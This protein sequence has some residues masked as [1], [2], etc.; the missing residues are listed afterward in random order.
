MISPEEIKQ[1]ALRWWT[2]I[3]LCHIRNEN[4]FPRTIERIG[5]VRPGDVSGQFEKTQR[6]IHTLLRHSKNETGIGYLVEKSDY[7]F[8]RTGSHE[9]PERI[10]I[11]SLND[12]LHITGKKKEW[13]NYENTLIQITAEIPELTVWAE[14]NTAWLVKNNIHWPGILLVCSYF[15]SNPRP[16]MYIRQLPIAIHTKFIEENTS[17]LQSLLDFLIPDHIRNK[18]QTRF[19]ERYYLKYDEPLIRMRILDEKL[20]I[21]HPLDDLSI[22]VSSFQKLNVQCPRIFITENK[23]NFLTL[24][25]TQSAI[26]LWSG[27]GFNISY[28]KNITL[29]A[30]TQIFYWGDID[31]HGLLIVN[32]LRSYYPQAATFLMDMNTLTKYTDYW[33][34]G[35]K[36]NQ[37]STTYLTPDELKLFQYLKE[38]DIRLEQ[39]RITHEDVVEA[40]DKLV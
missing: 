28:L 27:G 1:K 29:P 9:L 23:M 8:R 40:I 10:I 3:L 35:A 6:E 37:A 36:T 38:N 11:Q 26:A 14:D 15:R 22:P 4:A 21:Q 18:N 2:D 19:A 20:A 5:K 12:Y 25:Q 33:T 32:Q 17:L 24:P 31:T 30:S 7:N 39:E 34:K 16:K 13:T